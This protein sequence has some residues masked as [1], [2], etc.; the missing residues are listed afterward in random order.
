M[1]IFAKRTGPKPPTLRTL[2][3][4]WEGLRADGEARRRPRQA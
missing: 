4:P 1:G 3:N 2:P